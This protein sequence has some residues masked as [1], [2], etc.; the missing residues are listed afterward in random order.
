MQYELI[1]FGDFEGYDTALVHL[2]ADGTADLRVNKERS[3]G[4][5]FSFANPHEAVAKANSLVSD[6]INWLKK[7]CVSL[8]EGAVWD[9][10]LGTLCRK[11]PVKLI[12]KPFL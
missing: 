1:D 2:R 6:P 8:E 4:D 11:T 9:E 5:I 10:S 7:V 3:T 12:S